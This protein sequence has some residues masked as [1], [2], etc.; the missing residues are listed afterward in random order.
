MSAMDWEW[1]SVHL[2][3]RAPASICN[4]TP[5]EGAAD[6][7]MALLEEHD[8]IVAAGVGSWDV[9]ISVQA[10]SA[11][12]AALYSIG[13]IEKMAGKAGMPAW[14]VARVETIRQDLLDAQNARPT[15]PELVSAPEAAEILCITP[16]RLHELATRH[17]GFPEPMYEL[18]T[19]KLWLREAVEA[20]DK[21]W[22]RKPGRPRK[23]S[24]PSPGREHP[25]A[26]TS[27]DTRDD[28]Y[29]HDSRR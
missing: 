9:T 5:D 15:L 21:R 10:P 2:E 14:P 7:L 3:T 11:P 19:G 16:Q 1:Y 27:A 20:F 29:D 26:E 12:D 25:V 24:S 28:A 8:G 17:A 22:E 4:I 6:A 13:I 18:R 23:A